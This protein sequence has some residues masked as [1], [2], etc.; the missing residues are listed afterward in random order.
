MYTRVRL[1][2]QRHG[3]R[4]TVMFMHYLPETKQNKTIVSKIIA[5]ILKYFWNMIFVT[6]LSRM[7]IRFKNSKQ[8]AHRADGI[9][10][11]IRT[12]KFRH[13]T[14]NTRFTIARLQLII[15]LE[16]KSVKYGIL[17][18]KRRLYRRSIERILLYKRLFEHPV[19][20]RPTTNIRLNRRNGQMFAYVLRII[21]RPSRLLGLL[22]E[23]TF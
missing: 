9:L 19:C 5:H 7:E 14:S 8:Y 13:S 21:W 22:G 17:D 23:L 2:F 6:T 16:Q 20:K 15:I 4:R 1:V 12:R 18:V 3:V 11:L 10:S